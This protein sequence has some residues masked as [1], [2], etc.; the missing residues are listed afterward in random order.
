MPTISG[1]VAFDRDRSATINP[2]DSGLA[3]IPVVLQNTATN[4]R[5]VVLTDANGNYSF[6]NVPNGDYRIVEAYGTT[7]GV[8]TPGDFNTAVVGPIPVGEDPPI[9]FATNPPPGSTN[10]DSVTPNTLLVTV[11]GADLTNQD[12]LDGPVIYTPIEDIPDPCVSVSDTNLIDA[13]NNG[14]FGFFSPG[15]P[16]NTGAPTEPYPGVTP[17][18]TY[19]LPDPS[20]YTPT[21]GEYTVQN[22]MN[23]AFSNNLGAW[24]R[25]ADHTAGD[26]TG[27]MMVV[28]G[29]NP[30][31]SFLEIRFRYNLIQT[32]CLVHGF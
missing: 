5:L 10:L 23:D 1:R 30:E 20:T 3:N 29:F 9:S 18:F 21:D 12:F 24:W 4:V 27:R 19:V 31:Q 7:G 15:T 25:I 16:A 6:E 11:S 13:A 22:I 2:G 28:N 26:E 14:T 32:T 8:P 17:D